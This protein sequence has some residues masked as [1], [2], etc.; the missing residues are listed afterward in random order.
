ML[1]LMFCTLNGTRFI[2]LIVA[3]VANAPAPRFTGAKEL[4]KTLM[5]PAALLAAY[6]WSRVVL[7]A[8]PV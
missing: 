2:A 3:G 8:S 4:L 7:M 5:L 6:N 1:P